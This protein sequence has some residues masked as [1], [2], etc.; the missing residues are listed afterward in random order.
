MSQRLDKPLINI[1]EPKEHRKRASSETI[2]QLVRSSFQIDHLDGLKEKEAQTS[3]KNPYERLKHILSDEQWIVD[4]THAESG[5]KSVLFRNDIKRQFVCVY[6]GNSQVSQMLDLNELFKSQSE[7]NNIEPFFYSCLANLVLA[8][9]TEQVI[10]RIK[11]A[12]IFISIS[13][14]LGQLP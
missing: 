6:Q 5:H 2:G 12:R 10:I 1:L 13:I 14:K 8:S 11:I 3:A 7:E 9:Q 4:R